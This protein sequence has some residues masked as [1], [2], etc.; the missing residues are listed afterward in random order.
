MIN[1]PDMYIVSVYGACAT[2]PVG[3]GWKR[4]DLKI[5]P[6][7][8]EVVEWNGYEDYQTLFL[9]IFVVDLMMQKVQSHSYHFDPL[10][11][12]N[13]VIIYS[14]TICELKLKKKDC[15]SPGRSQYVL[16]HC[17]FYL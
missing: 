11:D 15:A 14:V 2:T 8:P 4:R 12:E 16:Q 17:Y 13:V 1:S 10:T 5:L 6:V 7:R 3:S 9:F